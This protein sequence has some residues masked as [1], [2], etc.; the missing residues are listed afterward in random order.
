MKLRN[1]N[2]SP[3]GTLLA[4]LRADGIDPATVT[5]VLLTHEHRDHVGG[6]FRDFGRA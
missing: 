6:L 5:D 2:G 4:Q 1:R 3:R